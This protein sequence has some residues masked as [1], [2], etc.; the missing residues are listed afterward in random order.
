MIRI[1]S[2]LIGAF[3]SLALLLAF[4]TGAYSYFTEPPVKSVE[5]RFYKHPE[6]LDLPSNGW[7]GKYDTAQL[8]RGFKVY[9]E[10]CAACHSIKY[11][12]F[13]DLKALGYNEAQVKTIAAKF[14]VTA[15]DPLTGEVKERPG[16]PA[17]RFPEVA[18]AGKGVPP[19][20]SLITKARH[21]G[22]AYLHSLLTGYAD[23]ATYK[24]A[25]G[26]S[27]PKE[28][29]PGDGLY[30][31][32]YFANLNLSMPAPITSEGQVTY[33]DGTK[34]TVDQMSKDVAAF[35]VWTAQ[36]ELE[37]RHQTGVW[38]LGFLLFATVLAYMSYRNIWADK[39]G[40]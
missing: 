32:P 29:Q 21:D 37:K 4:G 7:F 28:N 6:A 30:F 24:N 33:D 14:T 34:A 18:Y 1:F 19:D 5:A 12:A 16:V 22:A 15:K 13:R 25:D 36:P 20:L 2:I 27:L 26:E 23:P 38:W 9:S 31:N 40:H 17:D 3:F 11:V 39:K 8:Q 35:L 10:V